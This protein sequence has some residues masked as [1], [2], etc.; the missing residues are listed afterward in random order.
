MSME[1]LLSARIA[2]KLNLH[3][4]QGIQTVTKDKCYSLLFNIL[5]IEHSI[6]LECYMMLLNSVISIEMIEQAT[7]NSSNSLES[8]RRVAIMFCK[9][10]KY[11]YAQ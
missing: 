7:D 11:D 4:K 5:I 6:T 1:S 3:M 9:I 2:K 8:C 10:T